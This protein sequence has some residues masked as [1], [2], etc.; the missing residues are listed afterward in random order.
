MAAIA[1][2]PKDDRLHRTVLVLSDGG[3]KSS[4]TKLDTLTRTLSAGSVRV[5]AVGLT[6]PDSDVEALKSIAD[7]AGGDLVTTTDASVL[8]ELY[9][10]AAGQLNSLYRLTYNAQASGPSTVNVI[11]DHNDVMAETTHTVNLPASTAA[12]APLVGRELTLHILD[13]RWVLLAA[14]GSV[15]LALS[16]LLIALFKPATPRVRLSRASRG[17]GTASRVVERLATAADESL[18]RHHKAGT[19]NAKLEAAGLQLRPGEFVVFTGMAVAAAAAVGLLLAGAPLAVGMGAAAFV[20]SRILLRSRR[21]RRR[22]AFRSQL[23]DSLQLLSGSLRAGHGTM[24]AIDALANEANEPTAE[25]FR[26][27]LIEVRL[28]R[29]FDEALTALA[30]RIALEDLDWVVQAI[31]IHRD[32]GGDL[33]EVLDAVAKTVREREQVRGQVKALSA[34]G[35]LSAYVLLALPIFMAVAVSAVQPGYL[36]GLVTTP[37][38][39][40]LVFVCSV[41]MIAGFFWIRRLVR[42]VF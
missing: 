8:E 23:S 17:E 14:A 36:Q 3:D 1:V 5:D 22:A 38:G 24:Q 25:E 4:T 15:F 31:Q 12:P 39:I 35:R 41:L 42:V 30:R 10:D 9:A 28:G 27:L 19:L 20:G 33:A 13:Q 21:E 2:L 11:V 26:R 32:V 40:G 37:L 29:D 16:M 7:A 18:A 34:E 6:T